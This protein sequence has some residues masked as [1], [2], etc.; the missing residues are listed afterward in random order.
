M[1]AARRSL[2]LWWEHHRIVAKV[3]GL[4]QGRWLN[5]AEK[6]GKERVISTMRLRQ[7]INTGQLLTPEELLPNPADHGRSNHIPHLNHLRRWWVEIQQNAW[8]KRATPDRKDAL[9]HDFGI[10]LQ[11]MQEIA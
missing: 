2:R 11:I 8:H 4:E 5:L 7:S 10:I 3:L 9:K 1:P 6:A